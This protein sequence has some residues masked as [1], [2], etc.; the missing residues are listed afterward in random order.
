MS[1]CSSP[2]TTEEIAVYI[3]G[4]FTDETSAR[5]YMV[6]QADRMD[7]HDQHLASTGRW[8]GASSGLG[9]TSYRDQEQQVF[10][11]PPD[12]SAQIKKLQTLGLIEEEK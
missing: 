3:H 7:T 1:L 6:Q 9:K 5:S 12:Y 11:C 10:M 4:L 2:D 8:F